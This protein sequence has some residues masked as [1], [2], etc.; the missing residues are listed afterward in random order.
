MYFLTSERVG[1]R[2]WRKDDIELA[3]ALWGDPEVTRFID[4]R[5]PLQIEQIRG[6]LADELA[7]QERF[8]FQYWPIFLRSNA[9][10]VGCCGLREKQADDGI[11]EFGVHL[12]RC[13]WGKGLASEAARTVI[14]HAF[15]CCG[16]R[17]LFAGHHPQNQASGRMLRKLGFRLIGHEFYPP[18][19]LNHPSYLLSPDSAPRPMH[20]NP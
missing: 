20:A 14:E 8:G 2:H 1:F 5:T 6:K 4:A 7:R 3:I 19:G 17:Q 16:A 10:Y 15:Q 9:E 18:T 11:M 12:R 13:H